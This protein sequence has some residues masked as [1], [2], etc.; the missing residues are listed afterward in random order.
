MGNFLC[1]CYDRAQGRDS[2]LELP[3]LYGEEINEKRYMHHLTR[4]HILPGSNVIQYGH[5]T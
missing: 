1:C 2:V 3:P 5:D 4:P